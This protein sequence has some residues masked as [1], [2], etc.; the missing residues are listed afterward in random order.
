MLTTTRM[1]AAPRVT[2]SDALFGVYA[3]RSPKMP[4][5]PDD[6]TDGIAL[7]RDCGFSDCADTLLD[8]AADDS[9][10]P[11]VYERVC[12]AVFSVLNAWALL[13]TARVREPEPADG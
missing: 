3:N 4:D 6:L 8:L 9:V 1:M 10:S 5:A 2:L 7:L 13:S 12:D 11:E